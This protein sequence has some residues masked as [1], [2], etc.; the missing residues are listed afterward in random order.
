MLHRVLQLHVRLGTASI[1][2]TRKLIADRVV[3]AGIVL[4]GDRAYA[5]RVASSELLDNAI[6]YGCVELSSTEVE[7]TIDAELDQVRRRLRITITD[8][9]VTVPAMI[10]SDDPDATGGRGLVVVDGYADEIGWGQR[11]DDEGRAAGWSVWFELAVQEMPPT[12]GQATANAEVQPEEPVLVQP[13]LHALK[14]SA[15][16]RRRL[17]TVGRLNRRAREFRAA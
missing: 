9:G 12:F 15:L 13:R 14:M 10:G 3:Q 5:L 1:G 8:P 4:D 2:A 6:K 11:L 7:L 16:T 17:T